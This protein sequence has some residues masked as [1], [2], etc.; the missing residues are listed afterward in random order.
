MI[1]PKKDPIYQNLNTS[2]TNFGEL[3]VDLKENS[4]TGVVQ[5]SYWEYEGIL[6]LDT[7][8]I[9]NAIEEIND[10]IITGQNAVQKVT[11]KAIEK[12][13]AISVY[14]QNGEMISLLASV[15]NKEVVYKDLST[16]FTSLNALISKLQTE[17]HTGFIEVS[18]EANQQLGYIFLL[19][20]KV[21]DTLLTARGEEI[22]GP[23]VLNRVLEITSSLTATFSVY[24]AALEESLT[25]SEMIKVSFDL[26][27]LL[28]VWGAVIGSVEMA[29]DKLFGAGEFNNTFKDTLIANADEFPFLDPF[30]AKFQYRK[31]EVTFSGEV[32]KN[33]SR[34]IG[35]SLWDTVETLAE[36]AALDGKDL[37]GA[38]NQSLES[39]KANY[40]DKIDRFNLSGILPELF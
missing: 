3:L 30:A 1:F 20:G 37:I 17:N 9:I 12:D 29:A 31:G 24:K 27:Q 6:L 11:A 19:D 36:K 14:P 16:D 23:A 34:A 13:G 40:Q 7:G 28:E 33:F 38:I 25:E 15:A 35:K 22:S 18:F 8:N 10:R 2:F 32:T 26:P 5:V 39:V 21:I 4:F